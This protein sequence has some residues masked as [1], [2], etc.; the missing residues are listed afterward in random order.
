[1]DNPQFLIYIT[2]VASSFG[3]VVAWCL[4]IAQEKGL[5]ND[6]ASFKRLEGHAF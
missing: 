5:K 2:T 6:L 1:M 4:C 3:T